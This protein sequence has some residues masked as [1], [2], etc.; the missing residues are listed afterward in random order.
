MRLRFDMLHPVPPQ[1]PFK[2]RRS[3]PVRILPPLVR[4]HLLRHPVLPNRPS[5]HLQHLLRRLAP[6]QPQS[7]HVPGVIID[8]PNQ[9]GIPAPKT[10]REDIRLPQLIR[11]RALKKPRTPYV[12][13]GFLL[14]RNNQR[15]FPQRPPHRLRAGAEEKC[16]LQKMGNPLDTKEGL[17]LLDLNDFL[18]YRAGKLPPAFLGHNL[19][20][21]P[22]FPPLLIRL[23]PTTNDD[24]TFWFIRLTRYSALITSCFAVFII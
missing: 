10:K 12:V 9:I 11:C 4:Q 1:L 6:V 20:P 3:P 24:V 2:P 19:V 13:P 18:A 21:K 5:I 7:H 17:T 14:G 23:H 15:L 8:K 16:T 22:S